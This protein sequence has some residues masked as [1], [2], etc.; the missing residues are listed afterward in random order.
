MKRPMIPFADR[1]LMNL[2]PCVF[3][4]LILTSLVYPRAVTAS[5]SS[6]CPW[7]GDR[8]ACE[9][10]QDCP[11]MHNHRFSDMSDAELEQRSRNNVGNASSRAE[12]NTYAVWHVGAPVPSSS[13]SSWI[14]ARLC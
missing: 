6:A 1:A 4:H 13:P 9:A 8:L 3:E 10:F 11:S 2:P 12:W 7:D 14:G 5:R